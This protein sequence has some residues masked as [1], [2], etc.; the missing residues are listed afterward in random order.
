MEEDKIIDKSQENDFKVDID[1]ELVIDYGL[2]IRL[3]QLIIRLDKIGLKIREI[4]DNSIVL[5]IVWE[6]YKEL[7]YKYLFMIN[8]WIFVLNKGEGI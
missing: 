1:E 5:N 7:I 2:G 3:Y 8:K 4:F 6:F